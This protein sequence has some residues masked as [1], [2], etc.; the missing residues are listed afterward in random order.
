MYRSSSEET[1]GRDFE[2]KYIGSNE[3]EG[4][5]VMPK[6][7]DVHNHLYP[8]AWMDYLEQ[9]TQ[10][11]RMVRTGEVTASFYVGETVLATIRLPGH[12]DPEARIR[13]LDAFGIDVQILSSTIPT[14]EFLPP[15]EA[16]DWA[17]KF[18]DSF[19]EIC[20]RYPGRFYFYA[21]L[22]YQDIDTAQKELERAH[23]E[24]GAKG[25]LI[26]SNINGKPLSSA[27]FHPIYALAEK[28]GLPMFI[29]PTR[30]LI[31]DVLQQ[32]RNFGAITTGVYGYTLDTSLAVMGLILYGVLEKFP[33]LKVI[34]SHT[35]GVIPYLSG[36]MEELYGLSVTKK[37]EFW[38]PHAPSEYYRRQVFPDSVSTFLPAVRC[39]LDYVGPD[40]MLL[41]TD[42]AHRMGIW[43]RAVG[44]IEQLGVSEEDKSKILHKNAARLFKLGLA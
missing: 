44:L 9:R 16:A 15:R 34:H 25:L 17:K 30:P 22:S 31:A 5:K 11:P 2:A 24:L 20:Q 42:Y 35:G 7:I 37:P 1:K 40:H 29:H 21:T 12:Y 28:Y 19:A 13:D 18:N 8:K 27:E 38:L 43:D 23:I 6:S 33:G 32:D 41:G 10:P 36:R 26:F 39:C 14:F 3:M 4:R